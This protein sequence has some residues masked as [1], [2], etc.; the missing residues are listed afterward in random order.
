VIGPHLVWRLYNLVK[1]NPLTVRPFDI[2]KPA[3]I[4]PEGKKYRGFFQNLKS[5]L[6]Q[7]GKSRINIIHIKSDMVDMITEPRLPLKSN[8]AFITFLK[9]S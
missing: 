3:T 9:P 8:P 2:K 7:F 6:L 5:G 1:F 4:F